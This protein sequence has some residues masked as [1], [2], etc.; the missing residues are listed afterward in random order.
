MIDR[1]IQLIVN[2]T[3]FRNFTTRV[4]RVF[5]CD[6]P[7]TVRLGEKLKLP[8]GGMGVVIH[9]M[10]RIGNN[11]RI[12][13]HVTIGRTDIWNDKP[14]KDF[15]GV[16]IQDDA[17]VCAGAVVLTKSYLIIGSGTII[18]ANSVLTKSTG[19]NEVWAGNPAIR[20]GKR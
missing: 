4:L 11:V 1:L 2:F 13:Q 5:G 12:Y 15:I 9:P 18:G 7:S 8:H 3:Y 19:V 10:T 20:I 17:I 6:I 14:S 16:E